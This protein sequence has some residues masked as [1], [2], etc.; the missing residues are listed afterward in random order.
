[1]R[2]KQHPKKKLFASHAY[3]CHGGH[4]CGGMPPPLAGG[5]AQ[6]AGASHIPSA[7]TSAHTGRATSSS[8]NQPAGTAGP[9]GTA[10]HNG[11]GDPGGDRA[12]VA[13]P[14][15]CLDLDDPNGFEFDGSEADG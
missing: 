12:S 7:A 11:P 6:P 14:A 15:A 2:N 1:M 3:N 10:G 8:S 4:I 5:L 9:Q 13:P